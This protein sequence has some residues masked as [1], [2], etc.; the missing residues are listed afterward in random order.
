MALAT[1]GIEGLWVNPVYFAWDDQFNLYFISQFDCKHMNNIQ[2]DVGVICAIF[3]TDRPAGEHIFGAY[4]K[5][6]AQ[7][8][9]KDEEIRKAAAVYYGRAGKSADSYRNDPT[10]HLVKIETSALWYFDTRYFEEKRV[11]VPQ[12]EIRRL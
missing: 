4:V 1:N 12:E 2:S 5:G 10:W 3:P 11:E 9:N 6:I 8:L 7:I